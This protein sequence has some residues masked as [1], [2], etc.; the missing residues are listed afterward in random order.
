MAYVK[1]HFQLVTIR[2]DLPMTQNSPSTGQLRILPALHRI[3]DRFGYLKRDAL[4]QFSADSG[5]PLHRLQEVASFFSHFRLTSAPVVTV[6][7]CRDM[8]CHLAGAPSVLEDLGSLRSEGVHVEGVSW[9]GR[10]DRAPTVCIALNQTP[11][12]LT[13]LRRGAGILLP[14]PQHRRH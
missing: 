4:K 1:I 6:R 5:I 3:Q 7:V 8:A 13:G 9:L 10:C 14:G 12:G 2:C 11:D